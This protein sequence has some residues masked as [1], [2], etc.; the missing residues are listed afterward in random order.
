[1]DLHKISLIDFLAEHDVKLIVASDAICRAAS[2]SNDMSLAM[3]AL[4][5]DD[6]FYVIVKKEQLTDDWFT[7]PDIANYITHEL[8]HITL[9][10]NE[11]HLMAKTYDDVVAKLP[12]TLWKVASLLDETATTIVSRKIRTAYGMVPNIDGDI[13]GLL[14]YCTAY[15]LMS[16]WS[17]YIN[18]LANKD[19]QTCVRAIGSLPIGRIRSIWA[20]GFKVVLD[21]ETDIKNLYTLEPR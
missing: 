20:D 21:E 14:Q 17:K 8:G 19:V 7:Q 13:T 1:M 9:Y 10:R 12:P 11:P 6:Q 4:H 2:G 3:I 18:L 5:S 15:N 16:E